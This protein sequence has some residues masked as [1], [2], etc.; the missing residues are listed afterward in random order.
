MKIACGGAGT[1]AIA[2]LPCL[3]K[4][5]V[6]LLC[7]GFYLRFHL[8]KY[9][10]QTRGSC[11]LFDC[12]PLEDFKCRFTG[13]SFYTSSVLQV[14]RNSFLLNEWKS[15]ANQESELTGLKDKQQ[16]KSIDTSIYFKNIGNE[17]SNKVPQAAMK[18]NCIY[19]LIL[20]FSNY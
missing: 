16:L 6:V 8:T 7:N 1:L 2:I 18:S 4:R 5:F 14:N 10:M 20:L 12:G 9:Q 3:R 11:Y 19:L 17:S 15:Q 13:H